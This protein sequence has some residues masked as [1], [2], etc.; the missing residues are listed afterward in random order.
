[1][2]ENWEGMLS[3]GQPVIGRINN[4]I[5]I[6][7]VMIMFGVGKVLGDRVTGIITEEHSP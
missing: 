6:A 3:R 7:V 5:T 4:I 2:K 1:M